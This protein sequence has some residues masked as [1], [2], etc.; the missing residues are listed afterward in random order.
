MNKW[1]R[2]SDDTWTLFISRIQFMPPIK[3]SESYMTN[4][5]VQPGCPSQKKRF[6]LNIGFEIETAL[7]QANALARSLSQ[8]SGLQDRETKLGKVRN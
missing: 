3:V 7:S 6:R 1:T 5:M 4:G 8:S 2:M